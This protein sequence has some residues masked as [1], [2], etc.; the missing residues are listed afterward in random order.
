MLLIVLIRSRRRDRCTAAAEDGRFG[1]RQ[2]RTLTVD[3]WKVGAA[4]GVN[5]V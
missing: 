1:R 5:A 2:Q 3:D 4:K